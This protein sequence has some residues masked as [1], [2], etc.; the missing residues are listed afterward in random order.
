MKKLI[1]SAAIL[2]TALAPFAAGADDDDEAMDRRSQQPITLAVFGDWPYSIPLLNS[3]QLLI[4]SINSDPKV[5]LVLHVGDI[6]SGSMPCTGAGLNPAPPGSVPGWNQGVFDLFERFRDPVVYTPGD[7]EWTD[8]HKKKELTS[9]APLNE[10]A[11]VRSLFFASPG[12]TLG[13][14]KRRVL[15][16]ARKFNRVYPADAQF[17]ENVMWQESRVVFA[18]LNLPG[19]N[20][21]GLTWTAPFTDETARTREAAQR[22]GAAIRWLQEAFSRAEEDDAKAMVIGVQADMWDPAAVA[23]GGDGLSNYAIFVHELANLS[24]HFR[25]PVLL[26]NGDSHVF[27]SDRPLADPDSATGK[28]HGAPAVPNL[29][30]ITVQGSTSAPAEWLR[31]TIDPHS[32]AVFSWENVVYCK[33]PA[34]SCP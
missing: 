33:N 18:T 5:R 20:N 28:I 6:H 23:P 10:L 25:R 29:M 7:N 27:G 12:I 22:T 4:D 24:L 13:V 26:I 11:A 1:A 19:S 30:R 14:Q 21:D 3:A 2:A 31:L 8:C 15:T 34:V 9:G 17:V 16:Q 32:P